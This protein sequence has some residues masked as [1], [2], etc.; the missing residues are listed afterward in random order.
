MEALTVYQTDEAGAYLGPTVADESPLQPGVFLIPGGAVETP[1]PSAPEG[2][3]PVWSD[4]G[5]SLVEDHR[6]AIVYDKGT[7][8]PSIIESLGP[9]PSDKT[10]QV[11]GPD[12]I[13]DETSGAWVISPEGQAKLDRLAQIFHR[14]QRKEAYRP[15]LGKEPDNGFEDTLGDVADAMLDYVES[16]IASG[17]PGLPSPS[18]ELT[19]ILTER[20]RIKALY[21]KPDGQA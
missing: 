11:P 5:W 6:G 19:H 12:D 1:P 16:L 21:P 8:E 10:S 15:A 17:I 18:A 3:V 14:L 13:W 9:L 4:G 2:H 20:A 7:G